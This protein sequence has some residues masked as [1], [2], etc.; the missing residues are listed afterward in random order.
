METNTDVN[1]KIQAW[2]EHLERTLPEDKEKLIGKVRR[3]LIEIRDKIAEIDA[4]IE[5]YER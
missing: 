4:I 1:N 5:K 2:K 3:F